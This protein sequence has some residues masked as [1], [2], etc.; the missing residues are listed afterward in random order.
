MRPITATLLSLLVGLAA[1]GAA[2][3]QGYPNKPVR[4]IVPFPPGG[5]TDV[6][7]RVL[8]QK[9]SEKLGQTLVVENRPGAGGTI[10]S[11]FVA[12]SAP[13]GYTLLMATGSTH[14]IAPAM[15]SK[16]PYNVER[17][18]APIGL[19][20]NAASVLVVPST[21]PVKTLGEFI[22]L[23]RSK[24]GQFNFGS[25]G[26]GTTSHL[27]GELFKAQAG[28]FITHIP[29]RGT[30]LVLTD[31][32]SGQIQM[33]VDSYVTS[34][35]HIRDAKLRA[36]GVTS[37]QRLPFLPDV[38]TIAEQGLKGFEISNWYGLYAPKGTPQDVVL[39]VNAAFNQTLQ[40]PDVIKRLLNLGATPLTGTPEEMA[41]SVAAETLRWRGLIQDRKIT[42][43]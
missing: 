5:S 17:D 11:D 4:L 28:L 41:R 39:K 30:G 18:F 32:L 31:M 25:S 3:G 26:N 14:A 12:K 10:G 27:S 36:L 2:L 19:V 22:K 8:S 38:P 35:P 1:S 16:L 23:A 34:Q 40:D 21:L 43:E 29:Y 7:S 6:L 20:A 33:L 42:V 24:P 13:D 9:A 37:L 15:S